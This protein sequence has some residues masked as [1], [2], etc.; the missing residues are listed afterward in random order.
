MQRRGSNFH[1][2]LE[3]AS[4]RPPHMGGFAPPDPQKVGLQPPGAATRYSPVQALFNGHVLFVTLPETSR[5][6]I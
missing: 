4:S 3:G 6:I 2:P 5:T 1:G